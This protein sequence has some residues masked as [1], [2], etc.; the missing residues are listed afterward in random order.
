MIFLAI[1]FALMALCLSGLLW[2]LK[3]TQK[4]ER[5]ERLH[6]YGPK[7]RRRLP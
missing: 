3:D 2:L 7:D 1:A 5:E 6:I 4:A